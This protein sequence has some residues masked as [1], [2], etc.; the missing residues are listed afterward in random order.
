VSAASDNRWF[1]VPFPK[2]AA[3]LRLFCFPYAG[4]G[5]SAYYAWS[6]A[7][8]NDPI[9]VCALQLPGRES[10]LTEPPFADVASLVSALGPILRTRL[11]RP[12][13]FFGHSLGAIVA[14]ELVRWMRDRRLTLPLRLAVSG[15][16]APDAARDDPP[17]HAIADD[18]ALASA[19]AERY[20][21]IPPAVMA[22]DELLSLV[23]PALRADLRMNETYACVEGPPLPV[24]IAAYG[25]RDDAL[26][27]EDQLTEWNRHTT[28]R[29][30]HRIFPG[31][32]FFLNDARDAI[33][34]DLVTLVR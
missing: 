13:V 19:V 9:E 12:C 25:G 1:S 23:L 20:N 6:R 18:R 26:V 22:N 30:T 28:G 8:A 34:A 7:L 5:A 27:G 24:D 29:F 33:A 4:G 21:A 3:S 14:F 11:E 16:R 15:A 2:P 10:R 32:H 17:L 31:G